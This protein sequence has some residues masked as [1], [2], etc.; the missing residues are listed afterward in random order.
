MQQRQE[1]GR[2][3]LPYLLGD[4]YQKDQGAINKGQNNLRC[5]EM[6]DVSTRPRNT[7]QNEFIWLQIFGHG[8]MKIHN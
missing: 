2:R 5:K 8:R 6:C 7:I 3:W 1:D 4:L